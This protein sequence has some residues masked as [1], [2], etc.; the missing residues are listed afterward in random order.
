MHGIGTKIE[1][2]EFGEGNKR[3]SDCVIKATKNLSSANSA[4]LKSPFNVFQ[5]PCCLLS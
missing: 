4:L 2:K 5:V 3:L 1:Y